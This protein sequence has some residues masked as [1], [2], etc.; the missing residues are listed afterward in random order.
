MAA[1]LAGWVEAERGR[2]ILW[3]AVAMGA[4]ILVYFALPVE[5]PALARPGAGRTGAGGAAGRLALAAAALPGGAGTGRP[6]SASPVPNGAAPP[7]R[8]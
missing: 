1:W 5:P 7:S 6:A 3:L 2:F 4:A 8:R